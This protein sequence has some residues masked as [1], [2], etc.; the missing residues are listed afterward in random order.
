MNLRL[1]WTKEWTLF[2]EEEEEK[3]G[4]SRERKKEEDEEQEE[5]EE[6]KVEEEQEEKEQKEEQEEEEEQEKEQELM[7]Y[8]RQLS[9]T[10]KITA[11]GSCSEAV[12]H[13][14]IGL[15]SLSLNYSTQFKN[16]CPPVAHRVPWTRTKAACA[17]T[18]RERW[19]RELTCRQGSCFQSKQGH[20]HLGITG[21]VDINSQVHLCWKQIWAPPLGCPWSKDRTMVVSSQSLFVE[22]SVGV[23]WNILWSLDPQFVII[24]SVY[25]FKHAE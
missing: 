7:N 17:S 8:N 16:N 12:W 24:L 13:W 15:T 21:W 9:M 1:A 4:E 20:S 25:L 14:G 5:K 22:V 3:K 23:L 19:R 2:Q 18:W 10:I 11:L 6:Q